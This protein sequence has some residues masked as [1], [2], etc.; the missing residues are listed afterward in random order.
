LLDEVDVTAR[1]PLEHG[2]RVGVLTAA[3]RMRTAILAEVVLQILVTRKR[4]RDLEHR[5]EP[6]PLGHGAAPLP[7]LTAQRADAT[8]GALHQVHVAAGE[9]LRERAGTLAVCT[10][11]VGARFG[12]ESEK[13]RAGGQRGRSN[14]NDSPLELLRVFQCRPPAVSFDL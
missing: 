7:L 4:L 1:N 13:E 9:F 3:A 8:T 6:H 11:R 10:A 12:A 5:V 2:A 14:T